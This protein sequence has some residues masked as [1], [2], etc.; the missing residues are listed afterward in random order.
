MKAILFSI[1]FVMAIH[2]ENAR[3]TDP[4]YR[5]TARLDQAPGNITVT[6]DNRIIL[7]LHQFVQP[8]FSV[9]ELMKNGSIRPFPNASLNDRSI[10]KPGVRL[11]SV[12]GI[13]SDSRGVVW[14]L[15]NGMRSGIVP[16][17]VAWDSKL[18]KLDRV[19]ELP[20]P[21]TVTGSFVNDFAIDEQRKSI[22]IADPAN[23]ADAAL[24]VVDL[25]S[26]RP[27]R[28]LQGHPS[29]VPEP[30]YLTIDE[31]PVVMKGQNGNLFRPLIGV[32]PIILDSR[33]EWLYFGPMSGT[34]MYR[35]PAED[36]AETG[37]DDS[38]LAA[39][40]QRYSDKPV[41]DGMTIDRAGNLYLGDLAANAIGVITPDR[42]YRRLAQSDDLAWVDSF[43]FGAGRNLYAVVNQLHRSS[44]LNAGVS[45]A[46]PPYLVLQLQ[47]FDE[48]IPGH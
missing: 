7:S 6:V 3:A 31:R 25:I 37:E 28:I 14:M 38:Q 4:I 2:H 17:L 36:L 9:V 18:N 45:L 42:K 35:V 21:V 26:N 40:V 13:R 23:G 12:L 34:S 39:L 27:H 32:D 16:K 48:G 5:I 47:A 8:R 11:D 24:I 30:V 41:S 33:N 44:V 43:S 46:K 15:D 20:K 10:G 22:Y 1:L 29:V 19:I